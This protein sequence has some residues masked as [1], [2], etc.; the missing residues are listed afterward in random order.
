MIILLLGV[1]LKGPQKWIDFSLSRKLALQC[2]AIN[3]VLQLIKKLE[4]YRI[5]IL[6]SNFCFTFY[7]VSYQT[8]PLD[9]R[10]C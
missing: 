2:Y 1:L 6:L 8:F 3:Y 5:F 9:L 4:P 7:C 10:H